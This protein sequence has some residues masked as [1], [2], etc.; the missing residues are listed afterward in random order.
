MLA[1]TDAEGHVAFFIAMQTAVLLIVILL[2]VVASL[3]YHLAS[4]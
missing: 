2:S 3:I 1:A 4:I